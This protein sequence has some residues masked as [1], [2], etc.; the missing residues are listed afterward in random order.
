MQGYQD[1]A[2]RTETSSSNPWTFSQKEC[3]IYTG[4]L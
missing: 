4:N 2:T 3:N 1:I